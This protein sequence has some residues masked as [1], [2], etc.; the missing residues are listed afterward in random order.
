MIKTKYDAVDRFSFFENL[1]KI[2][3]KQ[4]STGIFFDGCF[5]YIMDENAAGRIIV[6]DGNRTGTLFYDFKTG[7]TLKLDS[8]C[9]PKFE[10]QLENFF[11]IQK[12]KVLSYIKNLRLSKRKMNTSFVHINAE[13]DKIILKFYTKKREILGQF[14][15]NLKL[16]KSAKSPHLSHFC[17]INLLYFTEIL[18][19]SFKEYDIIGIRYKN[20]EE[21][22]LFGKNPKK[23]NILWKLTKYK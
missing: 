22:Y 10:P 15:Q 16:I 20:P 2:G 13:S 17:K 12:R 19:H 8:S 23:P 5:A 14:S 3:A 18:S 1:S 4:P 11:F 21:V 7:D 9:I 6:R